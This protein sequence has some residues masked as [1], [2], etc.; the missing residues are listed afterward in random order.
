ML[1]KLLGYGLL[2]VVVLAGGGFAFLYFRQPASQPPSNIKVAMTPQRIARGGYLFHLA[3][4]DGCHSQRDT[5]KLYWPVVESGRGRGNDLGQEG[6]IR[7]TIPNITPD[8]ETGIGA[9]TDGEKIR[10]IREGLHKDGSTLFP[11]MPYGQYRYMSDED[12]Q[13]LVAYLNSLK[14][15]NYNSGRTVVGFPVNLLIK[16]EPKPVTQPIATPSPNDKRI[17]GEYL[18]TIGACEVCHTEA[19][20]GSLNRAKLFAGGRRFNG[21]G[22]IVYSSNITPDSKTG[23]GDWDLQR[24]LDRFHQHRAPVESLAP[25]DK[26]KFT[27]M[28]WRDL[29]TLTDSDLEAIYV[30]LR[31]VRPIENKVLVHPES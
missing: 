21:F 31:T 19:T 1:K 14:P 11:M 28:P 8:P 3:N 4:C 16:G 30:Y 20:R 24:F 9:W 2:V 27:I 7:M 22:N 15:V 12:V 29:A 25:F 10:A 23:I 5:T 13:A 6:P 18:T 17:Y 26:L